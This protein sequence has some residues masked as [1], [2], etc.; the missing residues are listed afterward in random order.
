MKKYWKQ[1]IVASVLTQALIISISFLFYKLGIA[2]ILGIFIFIGMGPLILGL[3]LLLYFI[4]G[5]III[6]ILIKKEDKGFIKKASVVIMLG[7][8]LLNI[9]IFSVPDWIREDFLESRSASSAGEGLVYSIDLKWSDRLKSFDTYN[10]AKEYG[11]GIINNG[12]R[13][14]KFERNLYEYVKENQTYPKTITKINALDNR[15]TFI[16]TE[17]GTYEAQLAMLT[18]NVSIHVLTINANGFEI[19]GAGNDGRFGTKDDSTLTLTAEDKQIHTELVL[20]K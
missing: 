14:S 6:Q 18:E 4:F 10:S 17:K 2:E 3:K 12:Y 19:V 7:S 16:E 5:S 20:N 1:L 9:L 8:L 11:T 15:Y 13:S